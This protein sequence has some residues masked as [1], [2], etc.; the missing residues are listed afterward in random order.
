MPG[1]TNDV[2]DVF[3]FD[4]QA[5]KTT[6]VSVATNGHQGNDG[7]GF[8]TISADGRF[9]VFHSYATNL[10]PGD[11]NGAFDIFLH[12]RQTGKTTRVSVS[13]SGSQANG[14]SSYHFAIAPQGDK[15]GF[16]SDAT[17][18]VSGDTNGVTDV[19]LR[20]LK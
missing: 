14:D 9:V 2:D 20:Q 7:S 4:A 1:D 18:L 13:S 6:R 17:N 15:V 11:T 10:V 8:P 3:V 12:D 19:F 5:G 16:I